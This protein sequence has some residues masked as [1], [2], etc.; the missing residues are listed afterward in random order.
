VDVSTIVGAYAMNIPRTAWLRGGAP[1]GVAAQR[2]IPIA[3]RS[4][5]RRSRGS[6]ITSGAESVVVACC[7][8]NM[9]LLAFLSQRTIDSA[10]SHDWILD[11]K[12]AVG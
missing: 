5:T 8:E 7:V 2:S 3:N 10:P 11:S 12:R 4:S 9:S 6:L 1:G